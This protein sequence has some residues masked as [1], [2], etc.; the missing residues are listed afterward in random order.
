MTYFCFL[1]C[2]N[3]NLSSSTKYALSPCFW[4]KG[5]QITDELAQSLGA[6][7]NAEKKKKLSLSHNGQ[8]KCK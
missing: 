6:P 4:G 2:L 7:L 1:L 8:R 3:D 5:L